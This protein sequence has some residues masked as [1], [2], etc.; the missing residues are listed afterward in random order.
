MTTKKLH[1]DEVDTSVSL[2]IDLLTEQFPRWS[3]HPIQPLSASG[4][5]NK[6]FKL[7][8]ELVVRL[9]RIDWAIDQIKK[10]QEWLPKF[11]PHFPLQIPEQLVI[12]EP[13]AD[14]PF[15]WSVYRWITGHT[16]DV[17]SVPN[18]DQTAEDLARFITTLRAINTAGAPTD[19]YRGQPVRLRDETTRRAIGEVSHL[20]DP[21]QALTVWEQTLEA[22]DHDGPPTWFHGDLMPGNVLFE[23]GRLKA[24]IDWGVL[25]AGDPAVDLIVAWFMLPT[26]SRALFKS[27]MG[28]GEDEWLRGRGWALSIGAGYIPYYR[29][30]TLP[31]VAFC[32]RAL[33]EILNDTTYD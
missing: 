15:Q 31:G 17:D 11:A 18:P 10:D 9:P 3:N 19:G 22:A 28:V 24:I 14:Y 20:I 1:A 26:H 25:G 23:D 32:Q 8:D 13:T 33:P 7:G 16:A 2:V 4:T 27:A 5:D 21:A 6:L 30:T 29:H 12:G